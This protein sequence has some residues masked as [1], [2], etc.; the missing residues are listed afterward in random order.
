MGG[1]L[2]A[3]PSLFLPIT[4]NIMRHPYLKILDLANLFV[5]DAPMKKKSRNLVLHPSQSN[6]KN[7]SENRPCLR[8][9]SLEKNYDTY[10]Y[11]INFGKINC[12]PSMQNKIR[13]GQD[14]W[15]KRISSLSKY[16]WQIPYLFFRLFLISGRPYVDLC[17][18]LW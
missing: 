15:F 14:I 17:L 18:I 7:G 10:I 9:L 12:A 1:A 13:D 8:G 4:Q 11:R 2:Y 16:P 6:L 3:P 5:A